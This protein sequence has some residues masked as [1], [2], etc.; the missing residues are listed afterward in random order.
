MFKK[1]VQHLTNIDDSLLKISCEL[2]EICLEI[3]NEFFETYEISSKRKLHLWNESCLG[4]QVQHSS[5][6]NWKWC[7]RQNSGSDIDDF[8]CGTK[9]EVNETHLVYRNALT[10]NMAPGD[11]IIGS[12]P[13]KT[14]SLPFG[15]AWP[16]NVF[17]ST[18]HDTE[19]QVQDTIVVESD[20]SGVGSYKAKM[21]LY[22]NVNFHNVLQTSPVLDIDDTVYVGV[23]LLDADTGVNIIIERAWATPIASPYQSPIQVPIVDHRCPSLEANEELN[24]EL[25]VNGQD[26]LSTF[27]TSVFKIGKFEASYL[28]AE[29][30]VCFEDKQTCPTKVSTKYNHNY[31]LY[32][33]L[34][35]SMFSTSG[36]CV[37]HHNKN[38]YLQIN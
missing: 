14:L 28:H 32:P 1:E 2:D 35:S 6:S 7:T 18:S 4:T 9:S 31:V 30:R 37:N 23:K 17:V 16:L 26:S 38:I 27:S 5:G 15:C 29:V 36:K 24:V 21:Y 11:I 34:R 20:V 12:Q 25:Y 13:Y 19:F 8:D 10:R 33:F 22:E 3:D